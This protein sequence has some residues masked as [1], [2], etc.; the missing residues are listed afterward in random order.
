MAFAEGLLNL[1]VADDSESSQ[2]CSPRPY[3]AL[4]EQ[5]PV[6]VLAAHNGFRFDFAILLC[7]C[8]RHGV[9]WAP[10]Q[11]WLFVDTL[12]VFQAAGPS[13]VKL[14]CLAR[15]AG[16]VDGLRAHRALDDCVALRAVT[17]QVAAQF[18]LDSWGLLR[19]FA[20][21]LDWEA[22]LAHVSLLLE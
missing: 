16:N 1:T 18:G 2:D 19:G 13:C 21:A 8:C 14:Q 22:S 9:S 12:S 4:P 6:L 11:R 15:D 5:P 17:C 7:E 10:L 3:P 20:F